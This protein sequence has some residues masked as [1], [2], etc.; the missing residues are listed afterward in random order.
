MSSYR[1]EDHPTTRRQNPCEAWLSRLPVTCGSNRRRTGRHP[2]IGSQTVQLG[3]RVSFNRPSIHR[4]GFLLPYKGTKERKLLLLALAPRGI[5]AS[6]AIQLNLARDQ[7]SLLVQFQRLEY[8]TGFDL[9][10]QGSK[11]SKD[12]TT[13]IYCIVGRHRWHGDYRPIHTAP[14]S[15]THLRGRS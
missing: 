14:T 2:G 5:S 4:R 3:S 13:Q 12:P 9:R 7:Y 8:L 1:D 10:L 15:S 6:R 11:R